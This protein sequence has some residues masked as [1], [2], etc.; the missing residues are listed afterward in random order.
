MPIEFPIHLGYLRGSF[1]ELMGAGCIQAEIPL[2]EPLFNMLM[3]ATDNNPCVV[4]PVWTRQGPK[5][6]AFQAYHTSYQYAIYKH[7][8]SELEKNT[9][10][11]KATTP[12]NVPNDHLLAGLSV[13][14]IAAKLGISI[15]E[16]RRRK[17]A[18]TL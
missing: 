10:K 3:E 11:A 8:I 13:K 15:G 1:R 4:C 18:G 14:Q 6:K 16:V 12:S 2:Q 7:A 5:C 17:T 9:R